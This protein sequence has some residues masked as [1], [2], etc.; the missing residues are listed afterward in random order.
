M[1]ETKNVTMYTCDRCGAI[2][3]MGTDPS[4]PGN[5]SCL[6]FQAL[7]GGPIAGRYKLE[8]VCAACTEDF[9]EWVKN[10]EGS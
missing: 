2:A 6:T 3:S 1:R 10:A 8:D 4:L 9:E 7:N 5:W